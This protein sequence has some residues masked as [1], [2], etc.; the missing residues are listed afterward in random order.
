MLRL[1][2]HAQHSVLTL[3]PQLLS[4]VIIATARDVL[5]LPDSAIERNKIGRVADELKRHGA[6]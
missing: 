2:E 1:F 4:P 3:A 5:N 6:V